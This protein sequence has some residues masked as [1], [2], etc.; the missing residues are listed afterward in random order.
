MKYYHLSII[1]YRCQATREKVNKIRF[2]TDVL[3]EEYYQ[4]KK[5]FSTSSEDFNIQERSTN[6][7]Q[8]IDTLKHLVKNIK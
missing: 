6:E 2:S 4:L 3:D 1:R 7:Q 8:Q 5:L